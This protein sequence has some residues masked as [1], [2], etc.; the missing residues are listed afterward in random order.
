MD[1]KSL[2]LAAIATRILIVDALSLLG[3]HRYMF[4][5]FAPLVPR[6]IAGDLRKRAIIRGTFGEFSFPSGSIELKNNRCASY[7]II[8]LQMII[9]ADGIQHGMKRVKCTL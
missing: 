2:L 3:N 8:P 5:Y 7:L 4:R 9:K 1:D 6:R